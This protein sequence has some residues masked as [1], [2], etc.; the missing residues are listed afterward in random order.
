MCNIFGTKI[1]VFTDW[2]NA[3]IILI[4]VTVYLFLNFKMLSLLYSILYICVSCAFVCVHFLLQI[5]L[6]IK[7]KLLFLAFIKTLRE[8]SH[9]YVTRFIP[10]SVKLKKNLKIYFIENIKVQN[11]PILDK[12][13]LLLACFLHVICCSHLNLFFFFFFFICEDEEQWF[14]FFLKTVQFLTSLLAFKYIGKKIIV[15]LLLF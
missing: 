1:P 14:F 7:I 2:S 9:R 15:K 12:C 5:Y 11:R 4:V 10:A 8:F 6:L 3:R 13:F